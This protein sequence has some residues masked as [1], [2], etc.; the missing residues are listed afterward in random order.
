[1]SIAG[2]FHKAVEAA[3]ALGMDT[4]QLFTASPQ[5]W[6]V[7]RDQPRS[8][9]R[10]H[11][12]RDRQRSAATTISDEQSQRFRDSLQ[13][14]KI[15][16]PLAH[17]SYLINLAAADAA[18]WKKSIAAMLIELQRAGAL[19]I[20]YVVVHPGAFTTGTETQGLRKIIRAIDEIHRQTTPADALILL[21]NTA[22]QGSCLGWRFEQLAR[23]LDGLRDPDRVGV[24]LDTCHAFAAGYPLATARDYRAMMQALESTVGLD[25]VRAIH[26]N[27][28]KRELG[29]RVDRH[30]HIGRGQI[31][32]AGFQRILRDRRFANVPMYLETPKGTNDGEPWDAI[33]LRVLRDLLRRRRS[34]RESPHRADPAAASSAPGPTGRAGA[35]Q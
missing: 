32:L 18:L 11:S 21:E 28:S 30:E 9:A 15:S 5:N 34:P 33:N 25:R 7:S 12:P 22:G 31:G 14:G 1:M 13:A 4:V 23:I 10:A 19:G 35:R 27:D 6:P 20:A 8:S 17:S 26:L 3:A 2:G 16:F 24:C 29:A